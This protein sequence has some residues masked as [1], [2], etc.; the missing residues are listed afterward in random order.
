VSGGS[1]EGSV[2]HLLPA[3]YD[4]AIEGADESGDLTVTTEATEATRTLAQACCQ[5]PDRHVSV[6]P[7]ADVADEVANEAVEVL[8]RVRA[9]QRAVEG[10]GDPEPLERERLVEPFAQGGGGPRMGA[11]EPGSELLEAALGERRVRQAVCLGEHTPH[12]RPHRLGEVLEDVAPLVDLAALDARCGPARVADRLA[13]AGAPVD[14]EESGLVEVE[15]ALAQVGEQCLTDGRVLG[16]A[17]AQREDVL[18]AL[19]IHAQREQDDAV[20]EVQTVDEDG[21]DGEI[22]Q[23]PREPGGELRARERH[24][25]AGHAALRDGPL[26]PP[27]RQG[28][29]RAAVLARRHPDGDRLDGARIERVVV[30]RVGEARQFELVAVDAAGAQ[31]GHED[32]ASAERD[33]ARRL[34]VPVRAAIGVGNVG[35]PAE[36]VPILFHHRAQH[37]LA[38]RQAETEERGARVREHVEQRQRDLHGGDVVRRARFPSGRG[39]ATLLHG[40]SF[41]EGCGD[42]RPTMDGRRSRRSFSADQFNRR[43]EIPGKRRGGRT[44][45]GATAAGI[46]RAVVGKCSP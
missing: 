6:A 33:L 11:L 15:P 19:Q 29:E 16:R 10:A 42:R 21:P 26:A 20:A 13:Q 9:P 40:G 24:E 41:C 22:L 3:V 43:R 32:T 44:A 36:P 25:A 38:G 46:V 7:A 34:P 28:I 35:R 23:R 5:P 30:R 14:D 39:C 17:L 31:P 27:R 8:D 18:L 12:A 2:R 37:L 45:W 4:R 1:V